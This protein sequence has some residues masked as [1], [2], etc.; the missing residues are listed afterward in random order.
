MGYIEKQQIRKVSGAAFWLFLIVTWALS[1]ITQHDF[2]FS[3]E[4]IQAS[5]EQLADEAAEGQ[6]VRRVALP[7]LAIV[8]IIS[9]V[10]Y[11]RQRLL[12]NGVLGWGL[13]LFFSWMAASILWSTDQSLSLRRLIAFACLMVTAFGTAAIAFERLPT[14]I[15]AFCGLNLAVGLVAE[16][17]LGTF[18]PGAAGY[19]FGGTLH[20]NLQGFNLA[21]L[22]LACFWQRWEV[23]GPQRWVFMGGIFCALI[24]LLMTQSRTSLGSLFIAILFSS[25]MQALRKRRLRFLGLSI[26]AT[27]L[28]LSLVMTMVIVIPGNSLSNLIQG[29]I[30]RERDAGDPMSFTGRVDLWK[31]VLEYVGD[32]PILGYGHDA[33]WS[34]SRIAD[35]SRTLNWAI[36]QAHNGYLEVLLNLGVP[37]LSLFIIILFFTVVSVCQIIN[38]TIYQLHFGQ[39]T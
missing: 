19:R 18:H 21:L 10:H 36:N 37:G 25:V 4:R 11:G 2:Y 13:I 31:I 15:I 28:V 26:S 9:L 20:P 39:I 7:M 34:D 17:Y 6:L 24:F 23:A 27:A 14:F 38:F 32:R 22:I 16:I 8:G 12:I 5:S 30:S 1:F 35:I 29:A 3:V 33:F